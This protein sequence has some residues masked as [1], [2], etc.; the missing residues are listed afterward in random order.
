LLLSTTVFFFYMKRIVTAVFLLQIVTPTLA[1]SQTA[2]HYDYYNQ[3]SPGDNPILFAPGMISDAFA[4]RD[5]AISPDGNEIFYTLQQRDL[6][7]VIMHAHKVK[8]KWSVPQVAEFSGMYN[9]LEPAFIAN[10]NRLF[11]FFKPCTNSV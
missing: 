8:G 7:S 6:V 4:N 1:Q 10:G 9:D 11:F 5:F 2:A 3:Q